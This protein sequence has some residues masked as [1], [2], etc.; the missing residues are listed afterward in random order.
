[1]QLAQ[2]R[3]QALTGYSPLVRELGGS[4]EPLLKAF[5]L[6]KAEDSDAA[7]QMVDLRKV[8]GLYEATAAKLDCPDFGLRLSAYQ[9]LD[10]AGPVALL[11]YNAPTVADALTLASRFMPFESPNL[12][13]ELVR[14][15]VRG[16]H[17][18][19]HE[20][21]VDACPERRQQIEY[22]IRAVTKTLYLL[23]DSRSAVKYVTFRH[24][25]VLPLGVYREHLSCPVRFG[26]AEN[27]VVID[28]RVLGKSVAGRNPEIHRI[29]EGFLKSVIDVLPRDLA[30]KVEALIS[31]Q[32]M[33]PKCTIDLI[34][35]Q[36]AMHPRTLQRRLR[37][38]DTRFDVLI[39][40]VRKSRA[41]DYLAQPDMR[42]TTVTHLL[43]YT[44]QTSLNQSCLRW[45]GCSPLQVRK[46]VNKPGKTR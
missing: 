2:I 40:N 13:F 17:R 46:Q 16:R 37:E 8:I 12:Q 1:M 18:I 29:A 21:K 30:G 35:G 43:G 39:D 3:A 38:D 32:L 36:L 44:R 9:G 14:D 34:A 23:T 20:L 25:A 10:L 28:S 11:V 22:D 41:A 42:L 6:Q 15:Q 31:Q 27:A 24:A 33:N 5:G 26:E 7:E 45:F 19:V 4:P